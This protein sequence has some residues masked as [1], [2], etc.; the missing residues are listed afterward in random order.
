MSYLN[1]DN[2][3]T[4][5]LFRILQL[6]F[7]GS[8]FVWVFGCC[9]FSFYHVRYP[10]GKD[11]VNILQLRESQGCKGEG[12]MAKNLSS[13]QPLLLYS[14]Y[15]YCTDQSQLT[16]FALIGPLAITILLPPALH[17]CNFFNCSMLTTSL[18]FG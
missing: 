16:C 10:K 2:H 8:L 5:C 1:F 7:I 13:V 9:P 14:D 18:P 12:V 6:C 17:P 3:C 15:L 4:V 11:V